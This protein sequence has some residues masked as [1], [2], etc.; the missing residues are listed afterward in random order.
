M[1]MGAGRGA[2]R[3]L[4]SRACC[5]LSAMYGNRQTPESGVKPVPNLRH[6][7]GTKHLEDIGMSE[8]HEPHVQHDS[9]DGRIERAKEAALGPHTGQPSLADE[10]GEATGGIAGVLLGAGIGSSAG[11]VGT[12]IRG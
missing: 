5:D 1:R 7:S 4:P 6:P 12:L 2:V 9:T 8:R 3:T 11:P 10:I